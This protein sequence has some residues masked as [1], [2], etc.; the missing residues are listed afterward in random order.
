MKKTVKQIITSFCFLLLSFSLFPATLEQRSGDFS[1]QVEDHTGVF[2]LSHVS[3]NNVVTNFFTSHDG[4]ATTFFSVK[5]GNSVYNLR[6]G[7]VSDVKMENTGKGARLIYTIKDKLNVYLTFSFIHDELPLTQGLVKVD[8]T[9]TNTS[10]KPEHVSLKGV[11]DTILGE[12][13]GV[14]FSTAQLPRVNTELS[15]TNM[16]YD[17]WI[18]SSNGDQTIQFVFDGGDVSKTKLIALANKDI[19]TGNSWEPNIKN[20]RSFNSVFS[21]NNS[22]LLVLW[23]PI[24]LTPTTSATMTFYIA[25]GAES[26]VPPSMSY[27]ESLPVPTDEEL[28]SKYMY[29]DD[30]GVVYTVGLSTDDTINYWYIQEMIRRIEY[31]E[32]NPDKIDRTEILRLNAEFDAI[33]EKVRRL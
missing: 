31:L 26:K 24:L 22:A 7:N 5:I 21:Y 33:I 32:E 11:F 15:L 23:N 13:T 14:H 30:F 19:L 4:F 25:L 6:R 12:S 1:L 28:L 9:L 2:T 10:D 8:I 17:R 29:R 16:E 27:I 18:R 20:G 3:S